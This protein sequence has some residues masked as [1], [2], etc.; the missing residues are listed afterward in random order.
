MKNYSKCDRAIMVV[1]SRISPYIASKYI[2]RRI[3]KKRLQLKKP[4]TFNEMLMFLKLERYAKD[5]LVKTCIDKVKVREYISN[6]GCNELLIPLY[7]IWNTPDEI[8]FN[9]LPRSFV[10][11]C[12]H[13][14]GYNLICTDK[15]KLD[16]KHAVTQLKKWQK[17]DFWL[18]Y[19]ESNYKNIPKKILA[20]QYLTDG[21]SILPKDY[22][23]YCFGGKANYVMVCCHR[24]TGCAEFY[25]FNRSWELQ[26][27]NPD[28]IRA[29]ANFCLPRPNALDKMFEY[30][31]KLS[32]PFP[33]VRVDLYCIGDTDIKFGELTFTPS[34]ALDTERLPQADE[35]FCKALQ[36]QLDKERSCKTTILSQ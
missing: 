25:F 33:F 26:R 4:R 6:M 14:C 30:A 3:I 36:E 29:P 11:K 5:P 16:I 27:I 7:G 20:E 8:P 9:Q 24:E 28:G 17:E 15:S 13:G 22:K 35:L 21:S 19:A 1:L 2:Y 10:L 18:R 31:D 12:N 32:Q 34:A 23:F